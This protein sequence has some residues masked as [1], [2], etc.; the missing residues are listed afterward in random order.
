MKRIALAILILVA[1]FASHSARGGNLTLTETDDTIRITQRG[2]PVLEYIKIARPVPEGIEKHFSRSG[3][4]H[5]VY[6]PR[7][8]RALEND[9]GAAGHVSRLEVDFLIL[10]GAVRTNGSSGSLRIERMDCLTET[11]RAQ[12]EAKIAV[13]SLSVGLATAY[14]VEDSSLEA[15][16]DRPNRT[17]GRRL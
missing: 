12:V 5:P 9:D 2:K 11:H 1:S 8:Q 10:Q 4:I 17:F 16:E 13:R 15:A 14:S 3:Y 6:T 7:E